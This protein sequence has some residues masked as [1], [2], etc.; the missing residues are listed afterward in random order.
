MT[1]RYLIFTGFLYIALESIVWFLASKMYVTMVGRSSNEDM[2][3]V[4]YPIIF[5]TGIVAFSLIKVLR[6]IEFNSSFSVLLAIF[7][8]L[9][10]LALILVFLIIDVTGVLYQNHQD[11]GR[12]LISE[13]PSLII[14]SILIVSVW[15]RHMILARKTLDFSRALRHFTLGFG[16]ILIILFIAKI[17]R[18]TG[19]EAI[20]ICY[21]FSGLIMLTIFS[22]E[23]GNKLPGG[24][25]L[26]S[27]RT[28]CIFITLLAICFISVIVTLITLVDWIIIL[29]SL[30]T[31]LISIIEQILI[32]VLTPLFWILT[33]LA[34]LVSVD[35]VV[36][37][38]SYMHFID[39]IT[40]ARSDSPDD[41]GS[42]FLQDWGFL[43]LKILFGICI[44]WGVYCG[45]R[46]LLRKNRELGTEEFES[47]FTDLSKNSHFPVPKI[48]NPF[49][50]HY[51][52]QKS[53]HINPI[54][55]LYL[56]SL[57]LL[58][59]NGFV[60]SMYETPLSYAMRINQKLQQAV[61]FE[62]AEMFDQA[63]YGEQ[64][65]TKSEL[66][67]LED[68]LEKWQKIDSST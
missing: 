27:L 63:R 14:G 59:Q 22:A 68:D 51:K 7:F 60:R 11:M 15:I 18:I 29:G 61:F 64:Y 6:K 56:R 28:I 31:L 24:F 47:V 62:I 66:Q 39:G 1:S 4:S 33:A 32:L 53:V 30:A 55:D 26:L 41:T 50:L 3:F 58:E 20:V 25:S 12:L 42:N 37:E 57:S 52:N 38:V 67:K 44:I 10:A 5:I 21:F 17:N 40:E 19:F 45:L 46:A 65:P 2:V 49:S 13:S 9:L 54:F 35:P 23:H 16:I 43:L 36:I 8:S 34:K 48:K